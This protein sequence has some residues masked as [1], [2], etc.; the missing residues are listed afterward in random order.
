MRGVARQ[1]KV[2]DPALTLNM[3]M[4]ASGYEVLGS[5]KI[6]YTATAELVRQMRPLL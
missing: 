6:D 2:I 3:H 5:G 1:R 4:K